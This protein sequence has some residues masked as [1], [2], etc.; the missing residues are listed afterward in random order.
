MSKS[1]KQARAEARIGQPIATYFSHSTK[2]HAPISKI[3]DDLDVSLI[4][5][6]TWTYQFNPNN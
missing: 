1:E 2:K 4:T 6:K 3:A 5:P